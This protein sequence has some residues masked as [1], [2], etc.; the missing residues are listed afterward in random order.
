MKKAIITSIVTMSFLIGCSFSK[1]SQN[2][3]SGNLA[4]SSMSLAQKVMLLDIAALR[5]ELKKETKQSLNKLDPKG[6]TLFDIAKARGNH[7]IVPLLIEA[8]C[9]PYLPNSAGES[10]YNSNDPYRLNN[11][12]SWYAQS[13][14]SALYILG[15]TGWTSLSAAV[16]AYELSCD[17]A[18]N[19]ILNQNKPAVSLSDFLE[20]KQL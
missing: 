6:R 9:S 11:Y 19:A 5:T 7:E 1:R 13:F 18:I 10:P 15:N 8:G 12:D 3:D 16:N 2:D 4:N 20:D 17:A 14:T